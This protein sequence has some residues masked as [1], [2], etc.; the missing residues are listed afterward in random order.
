M[1]TLGKQSNSWLIK[2]Q[3]GFV[4]SCWL[5]QLSDALLQLPR[6]FLPPTQQLGDRSRTYAKK[7][8]ASKPLG[9]SANPIHKLI[10]IPL[11]KEK[12]VTPQG[13]PSLSLIWPHPFINLA[14]SL[15]W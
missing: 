8:P 13:Y 10:S 9:N 15:S 14:V 1:H 2:G 6:T 7:S 11:V 3:S 4:E 12:S 5:P